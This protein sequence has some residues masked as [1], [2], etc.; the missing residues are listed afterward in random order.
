MWP[1]KKKEKKEGIADF[2]V[3]L[4]GHGARVELAGPVFVAVL[5]DGAEQFR[6]E[7]SDLVTV[8]WRSGSLFNGII[9]ARVGSEPRFWAVRPAL[10][11]AGIANFGR[12]PDTSEW[13]VT[14]SGVSFPLVDLLMCVVAKRNGEHRLPV[15]FLF[16]YPHSPEPYD[17]ASETMLTITGP[18]AGVVMPDQVTGPDQTVVASDFESAPFWVENAYRRNG[19][20]W[21]Q[22]V[23]WAMEPNILVR[24]QAPADRETE[25]ERL[26]TA[27]LEI[28]KGIRQEF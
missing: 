3:T 18:L 10:L 17:G 22:R 21:R 23:Y 14:V 15:E 26:R 28:A 11:D 2:S 7:P 4:V 8:C 19:V 25:I 24:Y 13:K 27:A 12:W 20:D 5:G 6:A 9:Y 1:F 16:G